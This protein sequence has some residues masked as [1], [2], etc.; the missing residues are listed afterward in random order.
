VTARPADLTA[1]TAGDRVDPNGTMWRMRALTAMGHDATRIADGPDAA[2]NGTMTSRPT[3]RRS[4]PI[5]GGQSEKWEA[6]MQADQLFLR[7]LEDLDRRTMVGDEYEALLAAGLLRKLL[8][9]EVPLVHQVNRYRRER[10]RFRINGETPLESAILEDGPVFWAISDAIDPDAFPALGLSVPVDA[11]L[12]QFLARTVMVVRGERLSVGD[13]IKQV[14]HIDGAV[15]K[16]RPANAREELLDE[17][18]GFM[19]F[20]DLPST[21]H[22]VQLIGRIVVRGLT[23]L[24]D[25]I[26][27]GNGTPPA[28]V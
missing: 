7:T 26:L 13:L 21:V 2:V 27:A 19:F 3:P 18:S 22:H 6:E 17:M 16:G 9:D 11:K 15:H 24:R 5:D 4:R 14:A 20:R 1:V 25:A 8:L 10:I 28:P 23:P 12:D